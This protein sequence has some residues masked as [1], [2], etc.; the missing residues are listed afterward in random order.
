[1]GV[2]Y[3]GKGSL[4]S[5]DMRARGIISA[6]ADKYFYPRI[7]KP[8]EAVFRTIGKEQKQKGVDLVVRNWW[9]RKDFTVCEKVSSHY[10]NSEQSNFAFEIGSGNR[11]G[12]FVNEDCET[13]SYVILWV[14]ADKRKYP[15]TQY[16][17]DYFMSFREEDIEYMVAC[18]ID[19]EA[20]TEYLG[21]RG[22]WRHD[23]LDKA[24]DMVVSGQERDTSWK[25]DSGFWFTYSKR[26]REG[27]VNVILAKDILC[28][29]SKDM[30]GPRC[31]CFSKD[32]L[33][34]LDSLGF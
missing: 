7:L 9:E 23:L 16:A 8:H 27:P 22:F 24:K 33:N 31:Y 10:I 12:W 13:G 6:Y 25:D 29:L 15:V 3:D 2:F 28:E 19:R 14:R 5:Y 20:I 26:L 1:M 18:V 4:Y 32:S 34:R 17:N 21:S 30:E 11:P